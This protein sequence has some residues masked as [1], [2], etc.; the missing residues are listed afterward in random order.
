M[1]GVVLRLGLNNLTPREL[2]GDGFIFLSHC[3]KGAASN[4]ELLWR[5]PWRYFLKNPCPDFRER[6]IAQVCEAH[7]RFFPRFARPRDLAAHF[8]R[9]GGVLHL[10]AQP[11]KTILLYGLRGSDAKSSF[12]DI[13]NNSPVVLPQLN[14]RKR[15]NAMA[16]M[17]TAVR[18]FREI[19]HQLGNF[20][21]LSRLAARGAAQ[22]TVSSAI[23][24]S[25][26]RSRDALLDE[27]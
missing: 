8:Q 27:D 1:I 26:M 16:R 15:P 21:H 24:P 6:F 14:V 23:I 10:K 22:Q 18:M 5:A 12:A 7:T 2:I 4:R 19:L 20:W 13:E 9:L 25:Y 3:S 11:R 17:G